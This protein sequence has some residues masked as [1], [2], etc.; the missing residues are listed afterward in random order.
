[1][2]I[3]RVFLISKRER[4][5]RGI[6]IADIVNLWC[7]GPSNMI[8]LRRWDNGEDRE[9]ITQMKIKLDGEIV[10]SICGA[11]WKDYR[12]PRRFVWKSGLGWGGY[13][14]PICESCG[15]RPRDVDFPIGFDFEPEESTGVD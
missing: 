13:L 2:P 8:G 6:V 4:E 3:A 11:I 9:S 5:R 15:A 14:P 10:C 1:M 12:G 7:S